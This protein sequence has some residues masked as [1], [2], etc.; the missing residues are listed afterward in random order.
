[1]R[2]IEREIAESR[3]Q[4]YVLH[5]QDAQWDQGVTWESVLIRPEDDDIQGQQDTGE[6]E[7][8]TDAN[9]L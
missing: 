1:M 6:F 4:P 9:D 8:M 7:V 2:R 5:Y 3:R